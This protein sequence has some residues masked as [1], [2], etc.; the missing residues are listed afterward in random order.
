MENEKRKP[1][2]AAFFFVGPPGPP[3]FC[4]SIDYQYSKKSH[5]KNDCDFHCE[6]FD[7]KN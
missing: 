5:C 2:L 4:N 6:M 3:V 7:S 1:H